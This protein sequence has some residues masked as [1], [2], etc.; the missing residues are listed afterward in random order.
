MD[1]SITELLGQPSSQYDNFKDSDSI[2]IN[3]INDEEQDIDTEQNICNGERTPKST[4]VHKPMDNSIFNTI[5]KIV[6]CTAKVS[7]NFF[8]Y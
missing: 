5:S 8:H 7:V 2:P 4:S 1:E 6:N 3:N